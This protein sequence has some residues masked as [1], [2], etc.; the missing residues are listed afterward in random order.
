MQSGIR[1]NTL[2]YVENTTNKMH[3]LIWT[4]FRF[5][6]LLVHF[7]SVFFPCTCSLV[8]CFALT[9]LVLWMCVPSTC[10]YSVLSFPILRWPAGSDLCLLP[11]ALRSVSLSVNV[12]GAEGSRQRSILVLFGKGYE[13]STRGALIQPALC[14]AVSRTTCC[15]PW[16]SFCLL[17]SVS[18][19]PLLAAPP[20]TAG[21]ISVKANS[22]FIILLVCVLVEN[23]QKLQ[24][25][26]EILTNA[27]SRARYDYWRRSKITIPFQQWEA[28]SH[29][30]KT[31]GVVLSLAL[32]E[33]GEVGLARRRCCCGWRV[34]FQ[35]LCHSGG[36]GGWE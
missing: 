28:L 34:G 35:H 12:G 29:S 20:F 9:F 27:E 31:V 36:L 7:C 8:L 13:L 1:D 14:K 10:Y 30:V 4:I 22:G 15:G 17:E 25:A 24:Q 18:S 26:K 33:E 16:F 11:A 32:R 21:L 3:K 19:K 6:F 2:A 23:F 5:R